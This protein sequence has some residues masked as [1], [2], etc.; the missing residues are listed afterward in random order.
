MKFRRLHLLVALA[1]L[2]ALLPIGPAAAKT[3]S[4][5]DSASE[6][7][8]IV[9][10][11]THERVSRA[12]PRDFLY[13][14]DSGRFQMAK[15]DNPGGGKGGGGGSDDGGDTSSVLGASWNKNGAV[16][17]TTGK[18]LFAMDGSYYV[19]SGSLVTEG[20]GDRSVVLTAAHCAFDEANSRF[21]TNWMFIPNYDADPAPLNTSGTFCAGTSYGCWTARAL[22]VHDGYAS[23]PAFNDQAVRYDF[24]FA[25]LN[26]GGHDSQTQADS[27]GSQP[28][29]FTGDALGADT[30]AF[31]YPA[32]KKYKGN[33]LVY[34]RDGLG[35]DPFNSN[36]TYRIDCN[37]TGGSSGGPWF[38]DFDEAPGTGTLTSVNSY[39]YTGVTAMHGPMF[40]GSTEALYTEATRA[41]A[42]T[43]VS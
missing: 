29:D 37:M 5:P 31:G 43:I 16:A 6:H 1:T 25:V 8:R 40:N 42:D 36:E 27:L 13:N 15:P 11:W 17:D 7:Q 32:A 18:V 41:K 22:V 3:T 19:C 10:F 21:A 12:I 24:A 20:A 14:P 9:D 2:M 39:G 38:D 26:E 28:I 23:Q 4:P 33:D 34:C 30:Y 35:F